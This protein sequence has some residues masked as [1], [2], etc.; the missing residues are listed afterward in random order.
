MTVLRFQNEKE[1]V[2]PGIDSKYE[3]VF[4]YT[5]D[6]GY[7]IRVPQRLNYGV[8]AIN[9]EKVTLEVAPFDC[10]KQSSIGLKGSVNAIENYLNTKNTGICVLGVM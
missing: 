10:Y 7:A 5:R 6:V 4:F 1:A 9:E 8:V 2:Q 3:L